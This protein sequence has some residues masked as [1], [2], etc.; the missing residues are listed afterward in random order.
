MAAKLPD[1]QA[2]APR[3]LVAEQREE[4]FA[5]DMRAEISEDELH[6]LIAQVAYLRAK[7]RGLARDYAEEDWIAA[8]AEVMTWLGLWP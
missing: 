8:E 3:K 2:G 5:T 4:P 6:A 7:E 1:V